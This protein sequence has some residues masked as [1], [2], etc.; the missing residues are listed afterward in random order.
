MYL[1]SYVLHILAMAVLLSISAFFSGS[2]TA[3][4]ALSREE[5]RR[6]GKQGGRRSLA[7]TSLLKRPR[8]LLITVLLGN[9]IVNVLYFSTGTLLVLAAKRTGWGWAAS[10]GVGAIVFVVLVT[11][12]EVLPKAVAVRVPVLASR[13]A[14]VPLYLFAQG[15]SPLRV[16][17]NALLGGIGRLGRQAPER[18]YVTADELRAALGVSEGEGAINR[19]ERS[20]IDEVI[21][22]RE[23]DVRE[24]MVP[25]VDMVT[26]EVETRPQELRELI[27]ETKVSKIP[28]YQQDED[29]ILGVAYAKDAVLSP[30]KELR[31][32][33]RPVYFVPEFTSAEALLRQFRE[34][35]IQFAIVVDEYGGV[36]GLVTLEDIL[37]EI[38]GEL[39]DEF[40]TAPEEAV[41]KISDG[42]Y[43]V[44]GDV[45]L[46]DWNDIF[47]EKI[48]SPA[49][50]TIGGFVMSLL[51]RMPQ[52]GD[53]VTHKGLTLTVRSA[54][55]RRVSELMVERKEA[56]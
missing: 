21:R 47:P 36:V 31:S 22:L 15:I 10:G 37:E 18:P 48:E 30:E 34:R 35:R 5:L 43:V 24:I 42:K 44:K 12:G 32:L 54:R 26:C 6:L 1:G 55:R 56:G 9:T 27:A 19:R 13:L 7:V 45:T 50:D 41:R 14:G 20:M 51:G 52:E 11:F 38:V 8:Q 16:V 39:H 46:K 28:V 4:F 3:L 40:E 2:E 53:V 33:V 49:T 25:R 23:T 17:L 29:N